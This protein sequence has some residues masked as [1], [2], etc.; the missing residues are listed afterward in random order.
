MQHLCCVMRPAGLLQPGSCPDTCL[1]AALPCSNT[2]SALNAL[3][4]HYNSFGTQSSIPK[5]RLERLVKVGPAGGSVGGTS[6]PTY[7]HACWHAYRLV[8]VHGRYGKPEWPCAI[9]WPEE[10]M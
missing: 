7:M 9:C 1:A 5:K 2:Y 10:G 3:A 8:Y 6:L 4:G